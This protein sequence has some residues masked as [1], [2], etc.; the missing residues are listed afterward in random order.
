MNF[1]ERTFMTCDF[2]PGKNTTEEKGK[3][4]NGK[5]ELKAH[6]FP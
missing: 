1:P 5:A 2:S 6:L 4:L 3:H